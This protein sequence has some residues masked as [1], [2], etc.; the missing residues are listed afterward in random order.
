VALTPHR[1]QAWNAALDLLKDLAAL[2]QEGSV[3]DAGRQMAR[4]PLHPRLSRNDAE[5]RWTRLSRLG[6][7]LAALL[8]ER[9]ILRSGVPRRT[10]IR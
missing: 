2:D 9:D 6:A 5:G 1:K 10:C 7:D 4:L 3:T 8:S